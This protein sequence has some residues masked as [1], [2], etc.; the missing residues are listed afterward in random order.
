MA[1]SIYTRRRI[2]TEARN[3]TTARAISKLQAARRNRSHD[4]RVRSESS[5]NTETTPWPRRRARCSKRHATDS[6][7]GPV[8]GT[9]RIENWASPPA[10]MEPELQKEFAA[11]AGDGRV[12]SELLSETD[13][14]RRAARDRRRKPDCGTARSA[15]AICGR[16]RRNR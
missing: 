5:T 12:G 1:N 2:A 16:D 15:R 9:Y 6:K 13:R 11:H 10:T 8:M 3:E 4:P 14:V 7:G